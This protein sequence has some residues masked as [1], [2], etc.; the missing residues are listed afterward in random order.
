M[1]RTYHWTAG[2]LISSVRK[3]LVLHQSTGT[4]E[5]Y[6]DTRLALHSR[7]ASQRSS[8]GVLCLVHY[9]TFP[10][11]KRDMWCWTGA[12]SWHT[13]CTESVCSRASFWGDLGDCS[14]LSN[15][16][17]HSKSLLQIGPGTLIALKWWSFC[18][19]QSELGKEARNNKWQF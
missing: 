10:C 8:L 4:L 6:K 7:P 9:R 12:R 19:N 11:G 18:N 1:Q 17:S 14:R 3:R 15:W 13:K 2:S 16:E 5:V